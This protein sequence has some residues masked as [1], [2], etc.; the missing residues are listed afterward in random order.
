MVESDVTEREGRRSKRLM[1][2]GRCLCCGGHGV[3]T[4]FDLGQSATMNKNNEDRNENLVLYLFYI[5]T[6]HVLCFRLLNMF[7][8]IVTNLSQFLYTHSFEMLSLFSV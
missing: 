1:F 3:K 8:F 5:G 7:C 6:S 2:M 4:V